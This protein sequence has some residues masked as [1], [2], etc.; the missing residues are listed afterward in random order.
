MALPDFPEF[1]QAVRYGVPGTP[2]RRRADD[3]RGLAKNHP[4]AVVVRESLIEERL[5]P[6]KL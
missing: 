3:N 4:D 6:P 2:D 1:A 5:F